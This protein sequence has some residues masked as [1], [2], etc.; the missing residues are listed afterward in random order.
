MRDPRIAEAKARLTAW[1]I[2]ELRH[3]C[4]EGML[5][6]GWIRFRYDCDG[7]ME[8]CAMSDNVQYIEKKT[9]K[10]CPPWW[11]TNAAWDLA[12]EL[13]PK[14]DQHISKTQP[15]GTEVALGDVAGVSGMGTVIEYAGSWFTVRYADG[16]ER[17]ISMP[18]C[19]V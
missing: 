7:N 13:V 4:V 18:R 17:S 19:K 12:Y 8:I 15:I 2:P 5:A 1:T 16:Q 9:G 10:P 3:V 14:S 11:E 6:G